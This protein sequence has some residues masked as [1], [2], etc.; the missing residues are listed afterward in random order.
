L[1]A[2]VVVIEWVFSW[3]GIGWLA[4]DS[5]FKRDYGVVQAVALLITMGVILINL[6]VDLAYGFLDPRIRFR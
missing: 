2:G 3:P 1:I 4:V 5:I 6:S